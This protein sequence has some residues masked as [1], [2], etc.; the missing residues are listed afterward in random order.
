MYSDNQMLKTSKVKKRKKNIQKHSKINHCETQKDPSKKENHSN[1][2]QLEVSIRKSK[3]YIA[4][5]YRRR[6]KI[7][8]KKEMTKPY[9]LVSA[10]F[11]WQRSIPKSTHQ[12]SQ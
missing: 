5:I 7:T 6:R 9:F 12:Q 8:E 1:Y 3:R 2:F 4:D 10:H 11:V